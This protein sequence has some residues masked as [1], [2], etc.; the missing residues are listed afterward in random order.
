MRSPQ[1]G[2]VMRLGAAGRW[3]CAR[4][5]GSSHAGLV[6]VCACLVLGTSGPAQA[7][8]CDP[9]WVGRFPRGDITEYFT[10]G[11]ASL[12]VF[13]DGSGPALY[14]AG[15]FIGG[16]NLNAISRWTGRE[17]QP[18]APLVWNEVY[19]LA[20]GSGPEGA[21][22]YLGGRIATQS[23]GG[24]VFL[25]RLDRGNI[26]PIPGGPAEVVSIAFAGGVLYAAGI[27]GVGAWDGHS[28]TM[29]GSLQGATSVVPYDDGTGPSLYTTT[30]LGAWNVWRWNGSAW[31]P[32]A[33][34]LGLGSFQYVHLSVIDDGTGPALWLY[35]D[36]QNVDGIQCEG[37]AR[38]RSGHWS[39]VGSGPHLGRVDAVEPFNDGTQSGI[40]ASGGGVARWDGANWTPVPSNFGLRGIEA[41]KSFD[42]GSGPALFGWMVYNSYYQTPPGEFVRWQG[43]AWSALTAPDGGADGPVGGICTIGSGADQRVIVG[44]TFTHLGS[45]QCG[46]GM[47]DGHAWT[48]LGSVTGANNP[49][50]FT[51][52]GGH[53][54][55]HDVAYAGGY[56]TSIGGVPANGIAQWDGTAW[57]PLGEGIAAEVESIL[58]VPESQGGGVVVGGDGFIQRWNGTSWSPMGTFVPSYSA[59]VY[60]LVPFDDGSGPAVFAAGLMQIQGQP[61]T[62][63]ILK[64]DGT[65]WVRP[66]DGIASSDVEA[67]AAFDDGSGIALYAAGNFTQAGG[68][69]AN[70]IAK[71]NGHTW[72]PVGSGLPD[73]GTALAVAD[74]GDGAALY[75]AAGSFNDDIFRWRAGAWSLVEHI[76]TRL[77]GPSI[78]Q[79]WTMCPS[80][81]GPHAGLYVGGSFGTVGNPITGLGYQPS[82]SL[83]VL[84]CG[85]TC[86]ANCDGSTTPPIL[87]VLDFSC[88]LNEFQTGDPRANCD[89]STAAPTLNVL[90]FMCFLRRFAEGCP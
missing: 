86:Y 14:S 83:A 48:P 73:R 45:Q 27:D 30:R 35:G 4:A 84:A 3:V 75:A 57:S 50:V 78:A 60:A 85:P 65:Q 51:V 69:A 29:L 46:V 56:F 42:D 87:N 19:T 61:R 81:V 53:V 38:W 40:Y 79:A 77:G 23:S 15:M 44:G 11:I 82:S 67:L 71:W 76:G 28:W 70:Y 66:G 20:A 22:L 43:G 63:C 88:F 24:N 16:P 37:L 21:G 7:Q 89:R 59:A 31:G 68:V 49:D 6:S 2:C 62:D 8:T 52:A 10:T 34:S 74:L 54:A 1:L 25:G 18:M 26:S 39:T 9:A 13:D 58:P 47:W 33:S 5:W 36:V 41:M 12:A 72:S 17:W 64:W 32:I 55:G 80:T 90:D